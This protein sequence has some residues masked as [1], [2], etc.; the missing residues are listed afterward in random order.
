MKDCKYRWREFVKW[1]LTAMAMQTFGGCYRS[2]A[3]PNVDIEFQGVPIT[4]CPFCGTALDATIRN[5][6]DRHP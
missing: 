1:T 3:L 5:I 4:H 6:A 2:G